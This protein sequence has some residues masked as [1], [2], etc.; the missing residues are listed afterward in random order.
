MSTQGPQPIQLRPRGVGE[1]L[2]A[3]FR[4]CF[5]HWR[6]LVTA[7]LVVVVPLQ[8]LATI[9][10]FSALPDG[11]TTEEAF[12]GPE[13]PEDFG[14]LIAGQLVSTVLTLLMILLTIAACFKAVADAY[15]GSEPDWRASVRFA[16]ARLAP[17]LWISLLYFVGV[18]LGFFALLIPGI[19]LA[20]A[21]SLAYPAA[22][23][24]DVR[25]A[26][27]LKRSFQLVRGRWWPV[28]GVQLVG[29]ILVGIIA[30]IVQF[31][32]MAPVFFV[33]SVLAIAVLTGL[34]SIVGY[35]I[36]TPLQAAIVAIVFFDQRV[37]KEGLDLELLARS[38]GTEAPAAP[39]GGGSPS[40]GGQVPPGWAPPGGAES[41]P[42]R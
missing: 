20:I 41:P 11:L 39:A 36:S 27:A 31:V 28:F 4:L 22:L 9:V 10:L 14:V 17:L 29:A 3:A 13:V 15:L 38:L 32:I 25:G 37:R 8:I 21:W 5:T 2:D 40:P 7:T 16:V 30:S 23:V 1:I 12:L 6:P 24:E 35:A 33:D 34:A 26:G 19:F 18:V 42:Q